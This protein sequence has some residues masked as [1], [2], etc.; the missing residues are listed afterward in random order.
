MKKKKKAKYNANSAIRSAIRRAFSR[1]PI[2]QEV[3]REARSE[4]PRYN[5]DGSLA[6]K[7][8]VDIECAIC[9]RKFKG[10]EVAVD[11]IDPVIDIE[12]SFQGWD[13]FVDRLGWERKENLQVVCSYK[14]KY[15]DQHG[16]IP[17]CHHQ[18]TQIERAARK[19]IENNPDV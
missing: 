11:H 19:L 9:H 18:K 14:L 7:P 8:H 10:T 6:K 13:V 2:V 3:L 1:S 4:R 12:K 16:D 5:K 15:K 17:S